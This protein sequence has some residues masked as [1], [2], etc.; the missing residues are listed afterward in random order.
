MKL[1]TRDTDYAVRAII[2]IA[3]KNDTRVSVAQLVKELHI[4]RPFLRKILQVLNKEGLLTS[5]K[6]PD[7]GFSLSVKADKISLIDLME[8]FQGPLSLNECMFKKKVCPNRSFCR[9]RH[10]VSG[11]E[12]YVFL[13]LKSIN[14]GSLK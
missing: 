12:K 8:I 6:G 7:G 5:Y 3:S 9:L 14:L 10:K 1:I 2:S 13:K 4:P 11:L